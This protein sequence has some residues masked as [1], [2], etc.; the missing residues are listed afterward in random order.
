MEQD[1]FNRQVN[2]L[3]EEIKST[4]AKNK[5]KDILG[6]VFLFL[7]LLALFTYL[8]YRIHDTSDLVFGTFLL[9]SLLVFM[10]V[11]FF[12]YRSIE[13]AVSA[14]EL[15]SIYNRRRIWLWICLAAF[16]I[17][18]FISFSSVEDIGW[19][20]LKMVTWVLLCACSFVYHKSDLD[21]D[22][23]RLRELLKNGE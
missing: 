15:I 2:W 20:I 4:C 18:Y 7:F 10:V 17:G 22:F 12:H 5:K 23:E 19:T 11:N 1:D 9:G 13:R 8:Y 6:M 3:M 14:Q 16:F 21:A